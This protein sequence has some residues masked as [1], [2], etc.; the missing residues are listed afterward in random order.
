MNYVHPLAEKIQLHLSDKLKSKGKQFFFLSDLLD[1]S[2]INVYEFRV[3]AYVYGRGV[4]CTSAV[5]TMVDT[6]K[7]SERKIQQSIR[8]LQ[9]KNVFHI[10]IENDLLS[11][12]E[13]RQKPNVITINNV[14]NW[15]YLDDK[16][17]ASWIKLRSLYPNIA[18]QQIMHNPPLLNLYGLNP[19]QFRILFHIAANCSVND[20]YRGGKGGIKDMSE[21]TKIGHRKIQYCLNELALG[22]EDSPGFNILKITHN[23]GKNSEY[24]IQELDKWRLI[25]TE[26][27]ENRLTKEREKYFQTILKKIDQ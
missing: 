1:R 27:E 19:Y 8:N 21:T 7:I 12:K 15:I 5:E 2:G 9:K 14:N 24:K 26:K 16:N 18:Y 4:K 10:E 23:K 25:T 11:N 17:E 13:Y 6:C 20:I 3:F 22:T